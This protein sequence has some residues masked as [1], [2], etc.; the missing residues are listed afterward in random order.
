MRK[1]ALLLLLIFFVS[2]LYAVSCTT[3]PGSSSEPKFI[4]ESKR[5]IGNWQSAILL[6]IGFSIVLVALVYALSIGFDMPDLKSWA[7][8]ELSQVIATAIII[9]VAASVI[10]ATNVALAEIAKGS[11]IDALANCGDDCMQTITTV[12][13]QNMIDVSKQGAKESLNTMVDSMEDAS[14]RFTTSCS[15]MI[16][17]WPCL[18]ASLSFTTGAE[19]LLDAERHGVVFEQYQ[20]LLASMN[21]QK[22]FMEKFA[23]NVGPLILVFGIFLR[24]FFFSRKLGG[25]LIAIAFGI[26]FA[27]PM[28]YVFD[29]ASLKL[30]LY[31]DKLFAAGGGDCPEECALTAPYAYKGTVVPKIEPVAGAGN[32]GFIDP[33]SGE[34][35]FLQNDLVDALSTSGCSQYAKGWA[36]DLASGRIPEVTAPNGD[37]FQSCQWLAMT[38]QLLGGDA[39]AYSYDKDGNLKIDFAKPVVCPVE[40]REVPYPYGSPLCGSKDVQR[41]CS[42][43]RQDCKLYRFVPIDSSKPAEYQIKTTEMA[44]CPTA[45]KIKPAL[46]SNCDYIGSWNFY[47]PL[48]GSWVSDEV[49]SQAP[50]HYT[51]CKGDANFLGACSDLEATDP[52]SNSEFLGHQYREAVTGYNCL[53]S[54][55]DCRVVM[56]GLYGLEK[57]DITEAASDLAHEKCDNAYSCPVNIADP[58]ESCVYYYPSDPAACA[59]CAVTEEAY[60]YDPP[61]RVDCST[62]C[63]KSPQP[64]G[65]EAGFSTIIEG[66]VGKPEV[67]NVAKLLVPAYLLPIFNT[68]VVVMFIRS[69]SKMLGGDIE[70][71][72]LAKVL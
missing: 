1:L 63:S 6:V 57:A 53:Y 22:F 35:Y 44:N 50:G 17:P 5:L 66:N 31:G 27:M 25:L 49:S 61:L 21:A 40:C 12:Y 64:Q 19:S 71:P 68:L 28:M 23:F 70:I 37:V 18:Q 34:Q 2:S 38:P 33:S 4:Q 20:N 11:H 36:D 29:M 43:L 55:F 59:Q 69:F 47:H 13:L 32:R 7:T 15:A 72:G 46:K 8:T 3:N 14:R 42:W 62:V 41:A 10:T 54:R 52:G 39:S 60:L 30:T 56:P 9:V 45:C 65:N 48:A 16:L 24:S 51:S 58:L 26:M 67:I